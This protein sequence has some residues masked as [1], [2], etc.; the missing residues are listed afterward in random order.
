MLQRLINQ[1]HLIKAHLSKQIKIIFLLI[2]VA[3]LVL[4]I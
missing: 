3:Y 4:V 2:Y 1:L